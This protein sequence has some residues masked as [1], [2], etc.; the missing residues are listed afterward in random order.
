MI[1]CLD[2]SILD[3]LWKAF[4]TWN[5]EELVLGFPLTLWLWAPNS[6]FLSTVKVKVAQLWLFVTPW[7]VQS[8]E[9]SRP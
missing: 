6:H 8:L 3:V 7:A 2:L 9:F 5:Q 4:W 1:T